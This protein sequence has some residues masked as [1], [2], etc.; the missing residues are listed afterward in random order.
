MPRARRH[1]TNEPLRSL[2]PQGNAPSR[3]TDSYQRG[4]SFPIG[5]LDLAFLTPPSC[6]S[7]G[8]EDVFAREIWIGH[9]KLVDRLPST[10][11]PDDRSDSDPQAADTGLAAHDPR[12]SGNPRNI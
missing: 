2:P 11:L 12:T 4:T 3:A 6:I 5:E 7:Q 9:Q 10:D 1:P 8:F